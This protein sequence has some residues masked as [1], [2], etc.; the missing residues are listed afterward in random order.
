MSAQDARPRGAARDDRGDGP[1]IE[2]R[3]VHV[4][5]RLR[6]GSLLHPDTIRAV[7]G[8]SL[9]VDRGQVLGIVGESGSGKSTLAR[10]MTGLQKVT[11]GEVL[12]HGAALGRSRAARRELGRTI[13]VV[14]QDPATALNP[15]LVV[16]EAL[17]D[18]LRVHGI[19]TEK[20]R[21]ER[22]TELIHQVGLPVSALDV[23]PRQISGG[24]RQR[25]AIARAL[26]L[27]PDVIVADEPTS[28]LD[29]SVRAQVLNLLMDLK[30]ELGLGLVFISHDISTVRFVSDEI[31]VM[32]RGRAVEH[33]PAAQ[34]FADAED[35]YTRSLLAAAP[36]LL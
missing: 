24:Q 25:V 32:N 11:S 21:L 22:V 34:V 6:T 17:M 12:F 3:D 29:V 33:G 9:S 15:R 5:H 19:G 10:V 13:S 16:R 20:E 8:I 27:R 28:A 35:P 23:L 31:L 36:T 7:D 30:A 2:L 14:F 18:P 1:V 26:T 4:V